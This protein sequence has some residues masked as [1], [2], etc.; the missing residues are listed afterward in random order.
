MFILL[1]I[2]TVLYIGD[3]QFIEQIEISTFRDETMSRTQ[4]KSNFMP[5]LVIN[6]SMVFHLPNN[7]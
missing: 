4:F 3:I 5:N 1:G 7:H 6:L 2:F